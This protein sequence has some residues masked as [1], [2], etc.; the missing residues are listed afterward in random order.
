MR[1]LNFNRVRKN[2][3]RMIIDALPALS[4][5]KMTWDLDNARAHILRLE[6]LVP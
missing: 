4:R 5:A 3:D 6:Y 2:G 1:F